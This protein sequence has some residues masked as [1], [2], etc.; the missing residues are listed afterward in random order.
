MPYLLVRGELGPMLEAQHHLTG[1]QMHAKSGGLLGQIMD[2]NGFINHV[3][4]IQQQ[5]LKSMLSFL[6]TVY[7]SNTHPL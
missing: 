5:Q 6:I 7:C 3:I 4:C 2:D 1:S